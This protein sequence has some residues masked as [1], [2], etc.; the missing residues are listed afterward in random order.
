MPKVTLD[1]EPQKYKE[2]LEL[3]DFSQ[4]KLTAEL[5]E[6]LAIMLFRSG[7]ISLGKAAELADLDV[8]D[9]L[10]RLGQLGI[11]AYE[12]Q[13]ED[14]ALEEKGLKRLRKKPS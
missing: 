9:M 7:R 10:E 3:F 11:P 5:K 14:W 8:T 13:E 12:Y 2:L 6:T 4:E 1:F